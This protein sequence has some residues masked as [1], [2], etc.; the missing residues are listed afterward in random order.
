MSKVSVFTK[1]QCKQGMGEQMDEALRDLVEAAASTDG[2]ELYSYHRGDGDTYWF[3]ALMS[4]MEDAQR[5]GNSPEIAAVMPRLMEL[6]E[7]PPE[8]AMTT[9]LAG[10]GFNF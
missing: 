5:H 4:S 3:F 8:L 7:G 6:L 9:P 1:F 2:V 10:T